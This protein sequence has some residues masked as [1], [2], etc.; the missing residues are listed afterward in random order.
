[1]TSSRGRATPVTQHL[2]RHKPQHP[3]AHA[4][5]GNVQRG[6]FSIILAGVAI[7][8][9]VSAAMHADNPTVRMI[10]IASVAALGLVIVV[11]LLAWCLPSMFGE[12]R[13]LAVPPGSCP[14]CGFDVS[15]S[16][17]RCPECDHKLSLFG[18]SRR[19]TEAGAAEGDPG[20]SAEATATSE[21]G[22][23]PELASTAAETAAE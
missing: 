18:V 11:W 5:K 9:G 14:N 7:M 19:E 6:F 3:A 4:D 22:A 1:M 23:T 13:K 15:G 12:W 20:A 16:E 10:L 17:T 21:A 8:L 2:A